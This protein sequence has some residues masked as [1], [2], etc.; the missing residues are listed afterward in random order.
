MSH[1]IK[2][3]LSYFQSGQVSGTRKTFPIPRFQ[4]PVESQK[5]GWSLFRG[6]HQLQSRAQ[7]SGTGHL[8]TCPK[9]LSVKEITTLTIQRKRLHVLMSFIIMDKPFRGKLR[10]YKISIRERS[11]HMAEEGKKYLCQICG[12]EVIVT[13][14]GVGT[15]VCCDQPMERK[16]E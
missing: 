8:G 10:L 9:A 5:E 3:N 2:D 7:N 13:I 11:C 4:L 16:E 15:L 14:S 12:Q 6:K 1:Q